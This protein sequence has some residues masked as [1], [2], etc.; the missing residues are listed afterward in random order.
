[1][2]RRERPE[3]SPQVESTRDPEPWTTPDVGLSIHFL[4]NLRMSFIGWLAAEVAAA[5]AAADHVVAAGPRLVDE[6]GAGGGHATGVR[7]V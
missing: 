4:G 3:S 1:M 5:H 2:V 6:V 7:S